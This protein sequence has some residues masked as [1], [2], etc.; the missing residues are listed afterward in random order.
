MKFELYFWLELYER[1]MKWNKVHKVQKVKMLYC[2]SELWQKVTTLNNSL[3]VCHS[4]EHCYSALQP[5]GLLITLNKQAKV[6]LTLNGLQMKTWT[7][8][9]NKTVFRN[10]W[11]LF[12]VELFWTLMNFIPNVSN[13]TTMMWL[14]ML[15]N[16]FVLIKWFLLFFDRWLTQQ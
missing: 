13:L 2:A 5:C 12:L 14:T 1:K 15:T 3:S 11:T 7:D 8:S 16:M 10:F 6:M 4:Q 9:G